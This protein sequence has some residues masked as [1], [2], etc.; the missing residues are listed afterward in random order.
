MKRTL[1]ILMTLMASSSQAQQATLIYRLGKDTVAVEQFTRTPA[2]ISGEMFARNGAV[3][4]RI[5][6]DIAIGADG[7]FTT[8]SIKRRQA[9][10]T[11]FP[12]QPTDTKLTFRSDSTLREIIWPDSTQRRAYAAGKA[13]LN[14]P[15]FAYGPLEQLAIIRQKGAA[16]DSITA[17]AMTGNPGFIGLSAAGGDTLRL[18]GGPYAMLVRFDTQGRILSVDGSLTTNKVLATRTT[19]PVD[20]AALAMRMKPTGVL[21]ARGN[22]TLTFGTSPIFIDYGRPQVRE[23]TVW[24]GVLVPFDSIWRAGANA[25][26]HL[27]TSLPLA[28]GNGSIQPG[29]YSLWIQHTRAGTSLI[30]NKGVGQWGT[31]YDP[32]QDIGKV[33]MTMAATAEFVEEYTITIRQLA[34]NRGAIDFA[35]GA[36]VATAT[37]DIRR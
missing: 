37:F 2:R 27:A 23:R 17:L 34:A 31:A 12:G 8:A 3:I 11:P 26:T 9:D 15:V 32:A 20:I 28:F 16:I 22:A 29:L 19:A 21:S 25:A 13:W 14:L 24:G 6:Y 35:W 5:Q 33:L 4:N 1:A 7:R 30:V 10:G 36:S 18:R